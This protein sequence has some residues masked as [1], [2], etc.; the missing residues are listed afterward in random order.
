MLFLTW[1]YL[2]IAPFLSE[3]LTLLQWP[4]Q[5]EHGILT[6]YMDQLQFIIIELKRN[7]CDQV[8]TL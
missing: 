6:F 5:K 1:N 3:V 7:I 2:R 4:L 8:P